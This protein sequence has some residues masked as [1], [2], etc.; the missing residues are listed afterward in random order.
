MQSVPLCVRAYFDPAGFAPRANHPTRQIARHLPRVLDRSGPITDLHD[1]GRTSG[2]AAD[3]YTGHFWAFAKI[4]A[5]NAFDAGHLLPRLGPAEM[6]RLLSEL[7]ENL[8]RARAAAEPA[9]RYSALPSPR[10]AEP[11]RPRV[12]DGASYMRVI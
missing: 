4:A 8:W 7:G 12:Y 1:R 5:A 11:V 10:H 3:L 2:R 9:A 6:R